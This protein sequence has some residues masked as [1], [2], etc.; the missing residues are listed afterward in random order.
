MS[1]TTHKEPHPSYPTCP[2]VLDLQTLPALDPGPYWL[3]GRMA[4]RGK[5]AWRP[6]SSDGAHGAETSVHVIRIL[7]VGRKCHAVLRMCGIPS[8]ENIPGEHAPLI[9]DARRKSVVGRALLVD[10]WKSKDLGDGI[11]LVAEGYVL[12]HIPSLDVQ[13]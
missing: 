3:V 5:A 6:I 11:L 10:A 8:S 4:Q 9:D 12:G 13:A 2:F 7:A 1:L